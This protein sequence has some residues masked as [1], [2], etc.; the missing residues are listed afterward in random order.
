MK[1][2]QKIYLIAV[3]IYILIVLMS[4]PDEKERQKHLPINVKLK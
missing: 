2:W 1:L 3:F 4:V